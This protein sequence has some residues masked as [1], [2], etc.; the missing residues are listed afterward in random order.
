[1]RRELVLLHRAFVLAERAGK[2]T[3]PRFPTVRVEN[4]RSG[5]FEREQWD[6]VRA[7]LPPWLQDVGDFAYLTVG[8]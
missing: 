4:A 2:A 6:A 1:M 7:Q 5:F 8:A 3:V